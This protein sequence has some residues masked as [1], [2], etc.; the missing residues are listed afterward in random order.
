MR[1][2]IFATLITGLSGCG[3]RSMPPVIGAARDGD[4]PRLKQLLEA[5][6]DPDERAGVNG[7]T[8]LMHAIHKNQPGSVQLLLAHGAH[9]NE[10]GSGGSTPLIM[11]AGY[12]YT[13][14]V[15]TLLK[16][17]ADPNLRGTNGQDALSAAVGG[18]SDMDRFTV[19]HCQTDTVK[20]LLAAAPELRLTTNSS[21]VRIAK[22]GGCAD[23]LGLVKR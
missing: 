20:A 14:I 5:G 23:V 17:G 6:A 2:L 8:P 4:L 9:V 7:W 21:A 3:A 15:T 13:D 12:G 18:V 19:G 16:A 10:R 22:F 11:A 1:L